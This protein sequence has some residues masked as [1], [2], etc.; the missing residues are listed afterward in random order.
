MKL[1]VII[2]CYQKADHIG[3]VVAAIAD[4]TSEPDEIIVVDDASTDNSVDVLRQLPVTVL[5]HSE[6]RGPAAARNTALAAAS[7][8]LVLC[9]DADAYAERRLIEVLLA[10]YARAAKGVAGIGGRGI[11][12]N[13]RSVYDRW[14]AAHARQDFGLRVRTDAPFLHGLCASYRR[15]ILQEMGGFDTFFP[16][17]AGEDLD[18]GYRLRRAGY[19]LHY[20]PSAIVYHQHNDTE[21]SLKRVQYNWYYWSYLAKKRSRFDPRRLYAGTVRRLFMDTGQDLLARRDLGMARLDLVIFRVKM[22]ALA[23]AMRRGSER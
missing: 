12:S 17:N 18:L 20:T 1:S 6:N 21:E 4:Q 7:G 3:R 11:E 9:I 13:I 22:K 15:S 5:S 8:D 19:R 2:P 10:E 14:R 16:L 23:D